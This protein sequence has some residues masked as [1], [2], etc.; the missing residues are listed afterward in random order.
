MVFQDRTLT[1]VECGTSFTFSADDQQFHSER[2]IQTNQ[3][4]AHHAGRRDAPSVAQAGSV[5]DLGRRGR[6]GP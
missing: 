5:E 4:G 3:N 1:C 6:H 2:D